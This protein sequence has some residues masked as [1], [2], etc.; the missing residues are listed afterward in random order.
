[1]FQ[2]DFF[3]NTLFLNITVYVQLFITLKNLDLQNSRSAKKRRNTMFQ[4]N[5]DNS[6]GH[7]WVPIMFQ[8]IT[9]VTTEQSCQRTSPNLKE[10]LVT[11]NVSTTT[12]H[13]HYHLIQ[14]C[15]NLFCIYIHAKQ[16][17]RITFV[18]TNEM[19]GGTFVMFCVTGDM[20]IYQ[21][22]NMSNHLSS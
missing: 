20:F 22:F 9:T 5:D 4:A 13:L 18:V 3:L 7:Q 1:M 14:E 16:I 17:K 12:L 19:T 10:A 6:E 15:S 8:A 2:A 21:V 11:T